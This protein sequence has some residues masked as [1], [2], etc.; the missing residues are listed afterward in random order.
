M[1]RDNFNKQFFLAVLLLIIFPALSFAWHD[2]THLAIA[3]VANYK[4]WFNAI[5]ADMAKIKAGDKEKHNHFVKNSSGTIITAEEVLKQAK[6][7]N[8]RQFSGHLY[9]AIIASVRDYLKDTNKGK[10]SE[11]HLGYCAHYVGDLS[12][13]LHNTRYNFYNRKNHVITDGIVNDEVLDNMS[14]IE[15]YPITITSEQ[16]LAGEIAR[17]ANI[18]LALGYKIES[19]KRLLTKEKAYI[20]L[21]HSASLL[22]AILQYARSLD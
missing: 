13:P 6:K 12:Q 2:E 17:I 9:G 3:K 14:S 4:K 18:S 22:K 10:Y 21:G 15:I 1:N 8:K 7:Y 5:G 16:E 20:Q 19:E 11:Y